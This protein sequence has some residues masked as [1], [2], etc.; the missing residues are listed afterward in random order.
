MKDYIFRNSLHTVKKEYHWEQYYGMLKK[1]AHT[2]LTPCHHS[3]RCRHHKPERV[4]ERERDTEQKRMIVIW[5]EYAVVIDLYYLF[6]I[7]KRKMSLL[8]FEIYSSINRTKVH[9]ILDTLSAN[10]FQLLKCVSC[11]IECALLPSH[12]QI[13]RQMKFVLRLSIYLSNLACN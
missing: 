8:N 4:I 11:E 12:L 7:F 10:F 2:A 9:Q 13:I 1:R 6:I 3:H 5:R